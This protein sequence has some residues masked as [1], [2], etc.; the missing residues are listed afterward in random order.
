MQAVFGFRRRFE[1]GGPSPAR[2][3]I[4]EMSASIRRCDAWR[5]EL[6]LTVTTMTV[7][8]SVVM[9]GGLIMVAFGAIWFLIKAFREGVLWGLGVLFVPFVAPAFLILDW[10]R[11][12]RPFF[13]QLY[14]VA[15][16]LFGGFMLQSGQFLHW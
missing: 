9:L 13:L 4:W 3:V 1:S 12:K 16:A 10:P 15:V 6:S 7:I 2:H 14:G 5:T 8:G 11:T